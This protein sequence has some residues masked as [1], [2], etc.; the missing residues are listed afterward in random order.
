MWFDLCLG[1]Q[2]EKNKCSGCIVQGSRPAN[3]RSI[4]NCTEK[5]RFDQTMQRL[6]EIPMQANSL[7]K[8]YLSNYGES[9]IDNFQQIDLKDL[10]L[11][12]LDSEKAWTCYECG[13]LLTA[14]RPEC[15]HCKALNS[16]FLPLFL[17]IH[18]HAG[19]E[20]H[21]EFVLGE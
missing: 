9:L 8:R 4:A 21:G 20:F 14:H 10:D 13:N 2:R 7:K 16:L 12:L 3:K 6:L 18:R 15:L 19:L 1:F 17:Y 11:F 5:Q